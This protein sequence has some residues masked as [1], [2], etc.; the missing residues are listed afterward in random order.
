M[1]PLATLRSL[2]RVL[3]HGQ[4]PASELGPEVHQLAA[5]IHKHATVVPGDR[6]DTCGESRTAQ[7][8]ALSPTMAA[9][10]ADDIARTIVFSRGVHDAIRWSRE[11]NPSR[12]AR[13]LYAGCGPYALLV[14]CA[15]AALKPD[16]LQI[17]LLDIHAPSMDCAIALID[18]FGLSA[19]IADEVVEDA[20]AYKIPEGH[21]PDIILSET[22]NAALEKEP[23]VSI[24][25]HLAAQAPNAI[26][27]PASVKVNAYF[28]DPSREYGCVE[29]GEGESGPTEPDRILLG[30]V[31]ELCA[32]TIQSWPAEET[33]ALPANAVRIPRELGSRDTAILHTV[34]T[35]FGEHT[36]RV[37]DSGLTLPKPI[38]TQGA[39]RGGETLRFC[40][41]LGARPALVCTVET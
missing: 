8:L 31:F 33:G 1:E 28:V 24:F 14:L 12:P 37:R 41:R 40:Y 36:L 6:I 32:E 39:L 30:S 19:F 15:M 21:T 18:T 9:R 26:L 17:T 13:L 23:Q 27:L 22:M 2:A 16:D 7:G 20:C 3:L 38:P 29:Y 35:V 5:L 10:C 11:R 4:R 25:R 34:V